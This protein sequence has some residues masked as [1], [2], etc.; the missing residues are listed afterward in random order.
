MYMIT[1]I[2]PKLNVLNIFYREDRK[3]WTLAEIEEHEEQFLNRRDT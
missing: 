3:F 2:N 1:N